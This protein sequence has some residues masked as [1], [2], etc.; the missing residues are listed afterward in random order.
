MVA[1]STGGQ[2]ISGLTSPV[3]QIEESYLSIYA[4]SFADDRHFLIIVPA[5]F[6]F[7]LDLI[8]SHPTFKLKLIII[9][10]S[11]NSSMVVEGIGGQASGAVAC[12]RWA[13]L[14]VYLYVSNLF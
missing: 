1:G 6:W 13:T 8:G 4:F 7:L 5:D 14:L 11:C 12:Q 3:L 10:L 9:I 2:V